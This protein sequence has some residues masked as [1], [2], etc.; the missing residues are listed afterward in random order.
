MQ[1]LQELKRGI[2]QSIGSNLS[3]PEKDYLSRN[4]GHEKLSNKYSDPAFYLRTLDRCISAPGKVKTERSIGF[5]DDLPFGRTLKDIAHLLPLPH[6]QLR[7]IPRP[8]CHIL[9]YRV[10]LGRFKVKLELHLYKGILFFYNYTFEEGDIQCRAELL[11]TIQEKY[12]GEHDRIGDGSVIIDRSGNYLSIEDN[13]L[14]RANY[15]APDN[16]FYSCLYREMEMQKAQEEKNE[17]D[18]YQ[19]LYKRL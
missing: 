17:L 9:F 1:L 2:I 15:L 18:A 8:Q 10:S 13:V 19:E 14:L 4:Y 3:Y 5:L 12:A 6:F 11:K 16:R 7:G